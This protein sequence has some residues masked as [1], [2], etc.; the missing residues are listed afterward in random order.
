MAARLLARLDEA[1]YMEVSELFSLLKETGI[2]E[3]QVPVSE[4]TLR[5]QGKIPTRAIILEGEILTQCLELRS[6]SDKSCIDD[7]SSDSDSAKSWEHGADMDRQ[8]Q[9]DEATLQCVNEEDVVFD[10]DKLDEDQ[11]ELD[12]WWGCSEA[13]SDFGDGSHVG[14]D[15]ESNGGLS[16]G[17]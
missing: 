4:S 14:S 10:M 17:N 13:G 3:S 8:V 5:T 6:L 16:G 15:I 12:E 1:T 9:D 11:E 7:N 2:P